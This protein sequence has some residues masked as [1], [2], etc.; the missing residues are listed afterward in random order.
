MEKLIELKEFRIEGGIM[1]IVTWDIK[2]GTIVMT[3]PLTDVI[4]VDKI[5]KVEGKLSEFDMVTMERHII[6]QREVIT[7]ILKT[8]YGLFKIDEDDYLHLRDYLKGKGWD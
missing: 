5:V 4:G 3:R 8:N 7:F 2:N 6:E 1:D